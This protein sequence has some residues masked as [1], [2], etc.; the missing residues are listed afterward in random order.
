[1]PPL[2]RGPHLNWRPRRDDVAAVQQAVATFDSCART[3]A[4]DVL[5]GYVAD[6]IVMLFSDQPAVVGKEATREFYR[7]FYG[8]FN[9]EMRHA[10]IET[11]TIG[12]L[13]ISRGDAGGSLTPKAGGQPMPFNN[14]YLMLFRR[15][16]DGS[17]RVWRV[18]AN[19]N[20]P[21]A[22]PAAG[23]GR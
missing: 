2:A 15:Q 19:S 16:A 13:V 12:D 4:L 9:I 3:G 10:P 7:T 17:L 8:T 20:V 23:A 5:M 1:M 11:H 21:P 18:A 14:K 22:P 6:D